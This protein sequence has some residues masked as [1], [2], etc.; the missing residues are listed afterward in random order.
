[1]YFVAD[2]GGISSDLPTRFTVSE[3]SVWNVVSLWYHHALLPD[4][5]VK[6][7]IP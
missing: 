1:M 5:I 6:H 3:P 2:K 7:V 4:F